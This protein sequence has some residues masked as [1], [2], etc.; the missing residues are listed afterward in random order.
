MSIHVRHLLV[1]P[2]QFAKALTK[3]RCAL[4]QK[5]LLEFHLTV[6][7]NVLLTQIVHLVKPV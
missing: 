2:T 4:V 5:T 3:H 1:G 6:N 7:Q